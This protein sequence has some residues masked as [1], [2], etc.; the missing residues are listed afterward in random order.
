MNWANCS[1]VTLLG[2]IVTEVAFA[3]ASITAVKVD[4]SKSAAPFTVFTKFPIRSLRL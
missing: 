1:G 2:S 3:L 4:F